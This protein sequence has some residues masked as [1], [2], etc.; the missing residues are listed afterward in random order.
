MLLRLKSKFD[1]LKITSWFCVINFLLFFLL[2]IFLI[3]SYDADI[4][5]VENNVAYSISKMLCGDALYENP[6]SGSFDI[7]QYTPLYYYVATGI[8]QLFHLNPLNDL[9]AIYAVGRSL[10]L[11]FNLLSLLVLFLML[12]RQ[13]K[14]NKQLAIIATCTYFIHLTRI[15]FA[16]RPDALFALLFL[17][18]L[19]CFV[20]FFQQHKHKNIYLIGGIL[21]A[22]L[23]VFVKQTGIQYLV[24]IPAYF[25]LTKEFKIF[26]IATLS[27]A[28]GLV[29]GL[30]LFDQMY[31]GNF[32][33]NTFK[34]INN[35]VSIARVYDV[36]SHFFLKYQV[37]M[38]LG[39]LLSVRY[40]FGSDD[41]VF[42]FLSFMNV[43]IFS[44]AVVTSV[45]EGSWINYYNEFIALS[46]ILIA[47]EVKALIDH[48][49]F[50][51]RLASFVSYAAALY[52]IVLLPNVMLQKIFHE[53]FNHLKNT[54]AIFAQRQQTAKWL[55]NHLKKDTYFISFDDQINAMLPTHAMV[56]N[57][58]IVPTQS[59]FNYKQVTEH[60]YSGLIKYIIK[61]RTS[62]ISEFMGADFTGCKEVFSTADYVV[63]ENKSN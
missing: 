20:F 26:L 42:K 32:L 27:L 29:V 54:S 38:V 22:V 14:I 35:G 31:P 16:A 46:I 39:M 25:I 48:G 62:A 28:I 60:Y 52:L 19:A 43:G 3:G 8:S 57:K 50:Q 4:G 33:L 58:D 63:L 18:M 47:L 12:N 44:F 45:K 41:K 24:I 5:G 56:P 11:C 51:D 9:H 34:G 23:S 17:L 40:F 37:I 36:F 55:S 6:E 13:F 7:T 21:I 2:R 53:H 49:I 30:F 15:H 10:S 61:P 1:L 59:K